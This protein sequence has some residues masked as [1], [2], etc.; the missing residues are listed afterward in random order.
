MVRHCRLDT[1]YLQVLLHKTI[2]NKQYSQQYII[3]LQTTQYSQYTNHNRSYTSTN[4]NDNHIFS[5][6]FGGSCSSSM[7][8]CLDDISLRSSSLLSLMMSLIILF[9]SSALSAFSV[10]TLVSVSVTSLPDIICFLYWYWVS[11]SVRIL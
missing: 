10:A 8:S 3:Q 1:L 2:H 4:N 11:S 9:T 5:M 7:E 6:V